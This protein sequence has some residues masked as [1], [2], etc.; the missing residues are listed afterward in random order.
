[1]KKNQLTEKDL[2]S[3]EMENSTFYKKNISYNHHVDC[4]PNRQIF[5]VPLSLEANLDLNAVL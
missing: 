5:N 1:M 4:K 3:L 2:M